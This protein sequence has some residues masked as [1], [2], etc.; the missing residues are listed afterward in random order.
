MAIDE[1]AGGAM[2]TRILA[3]QLRFFCRQTRQ[4]VL[5]HAFVAVAATALLLTQPVDRTALFVWAALTRLDLVAEVDSWTLM[6][7]MMGTY[8]GVSMII[9]FRRGLTP[10]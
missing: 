6:T 9:S 10:G 7:V 2:T 3:E 5:G 8:L 1:D 4:S